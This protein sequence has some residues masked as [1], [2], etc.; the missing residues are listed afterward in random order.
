MLINIADK[1][2]LIITFSMIALSLELT[3]FPEWLASKSTFCNTPKRLIL[4]WFCTAFFMSGVFNDMTVAALLAPLAIR[5]AQQINFPRIDL[6]LLSVAF[7]IS[8]GGDLTVFGGNDNLMALGLL[9]DTPYALTKLDWSFT[10]IPSTLLI[11]IIAAAI[12]TFAVR[13]VTWTIA[14]RAKDITV[15]WFFVCLCLFAIM[16]AFFV[17]A[18][19]I[20]CFA[21]LTLVMQRAVKKIPAAIPYK[22]LLIWTVAFV[23]GKL[24]NQWLA[25]F[26]T[27]PTNILLLT[28]LLILLTN[29]FTNTALMSLA[30]PFILAANLPASSCYAAIK[31]VNIAYIT[32]YGNSCLAVSSGYGLKQRQ[33]LIYGLPLLFSSW[34]I[35]N[36]CF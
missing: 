20:T 23:V 2:L 11:G 18:G 12:C 19:Y 1:L 28:A 7:G 14:N 26:I 36:I 24:L 25:D 8:T 22:A 21:L 33:L 15:D 34:L 17:P 9:Q 30:L 27:I 13:K 16:L 32:I 29:F 10:F 4:F 5:S 35:I 6:V 3:R 31:A